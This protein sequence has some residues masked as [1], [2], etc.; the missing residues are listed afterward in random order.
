[1]VDFDLLEGSLVDSQSESEVKLDSEP[2]STID[3]G[4]V[5]DFDS[6]TGFDSTTE[7]HFWLAI[8]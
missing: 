7:E 5:A 3:S 6:T 4:F 1:M 2:G 8:L